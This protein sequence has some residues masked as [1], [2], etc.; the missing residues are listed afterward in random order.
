[1]PEEY[2]QKDGYQLHTKWNDVIFGGSALVGTLEDVTLEDIE[3]YLGEPM[4]VGGKMIDKRWLLR[5]DD[6]IVATIFNYKGEDKVRV[7]GFREVSR[8][9]V[10]ELI[11]ECKS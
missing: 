11:E 6:G 9:H 8:E 7:G 10:E 4:I 1:M 5:F 3:H 2:V